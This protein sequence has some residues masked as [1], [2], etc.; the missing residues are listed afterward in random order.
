M[1]HTNQTEHYNLPQFVGSDI[2]SWLVDVNQAYTAIDSAIYAAKNTADVA[3]NTA[4]SANT[5]A[6]DAESAAEVATTTA[7]SAKAIA[8][9]NTLQ[10]AEVSKKAGNW[11]LGQV[12]AIGTS[13][14][15]VTNANIH[16][17]SIIDVYYSQESVAAGAEAGITYEVAEGSITF[18]LASSAAE[19]ITVSLHVVNP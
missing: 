3:S 6:Q 8:D 11:I 13:T 17:N 7:N 12:I 15:T 2:P 16:P 1:A 10:I 4:G 19:N 14:L 9:G 5:V 18:T